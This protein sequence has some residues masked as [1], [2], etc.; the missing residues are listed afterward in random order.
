[1]NGSNNY[2]KLFHT[3]I[4]KISTMA[5]K[6]TLKDRKKKEQ[7]KG[8]VILNIHINRNLTSLK[9]SYRNYFGFENTMKVTKQD[10]EAWAASLAESD[11]DDF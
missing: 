11:M 10:I 2:A 8:G 5:N 4:I 7:R 6:S 3:K 1:M 9:E